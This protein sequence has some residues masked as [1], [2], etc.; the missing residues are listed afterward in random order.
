MDKL[1][2][3][4]LGIMLNILK[5]KKIELQDSS[6]NIEWHRQIDQDC[7]KID[8]ELNSRIEFVS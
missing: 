8:D 1:S 3:E 2:V 7:K 4:S 5:N 6:G